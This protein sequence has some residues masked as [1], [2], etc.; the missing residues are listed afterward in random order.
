[1]PK[2]NNAVGAGAKWYSGKELKE[3]LNPKKKKRGEK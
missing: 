3:W 1:M 2:L